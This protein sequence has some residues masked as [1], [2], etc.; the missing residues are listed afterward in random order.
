MGAPCALSRTVL[1]TAPSEGSQLGPCVCR[2][3]TLS[4]PCRFRLLREL[5]GVGRT[6]SRSNSS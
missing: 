3:L 1:W 5:G 2:L 6:C 4:E